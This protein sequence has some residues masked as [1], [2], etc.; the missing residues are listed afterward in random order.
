MFEDRKEKAIKTIE[1][2]EVKVQ[3]II[4]VRSINCF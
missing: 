4:Q 3:E 2:K 1:K